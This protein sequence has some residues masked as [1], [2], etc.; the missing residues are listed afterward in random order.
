MQ[1]GSWDSLLGDLEFK[2]TNRLKRCQD[3]LQRWNWNVFGNVNKVL[4]KKK[5][6]KYTPTARIHYPW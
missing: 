5:K 6:A 2:I 3:Q 4:K 1:R